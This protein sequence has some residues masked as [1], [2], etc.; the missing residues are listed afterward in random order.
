MDLKQMQEMSEMLEMLEMLEKMTVMVMHETIDIAWSDSE[1][2]LMERFH[3]ALAIP[4]DDE[5][6]GPFAV[7]QTVGTLGVALEARYHVDRDKLMQILRD[8]DP[9]FVKELQQP[10][11]GKVDWRT[12]GDRPYDH[13][14]DMYVDEHEDYTEGD[15]LNI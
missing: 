6:P 2:E 1:D 4:N 5:N 15:K 9:E 14:F 12:D 13:L 7:M 11:T 3:K 10:I 8:S